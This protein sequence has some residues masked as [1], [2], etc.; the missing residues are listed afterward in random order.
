[1]NPVS[2]LP[3]VA[4]VHAEA[5]REP[6]DP[7]LHAQVE[8][9]WASLLDQADSIADQITLTL[10][11]RDQGLFQRSARPPGRGPGQHPRADPAGYR[12]AGRCGEP[13]SKA[14]E[15]WR[16]TGRRRARQGVPM[17]LILSA[18]TLGTRALWEALLAQAASGKLDVEDQ[19]LLIAGQRVWSALDVQ[20]AVLIES[21]RRESARLQ[22]RDL[23]RQQ[24]IL[25]ALIE[26]RGADPHFATEA[27]EVLGIGTGVRI[28]C[29]V[30]P[31]DGSLDEPLTAPEDRLERLEIA[32]HWHV[33]GGLY[34]GLLAGPLPDDDG[35]VQLL[36]PLAVGRVGLASSAD[37]LA[38]F[39]TAF[40]L[41]TRA[42]ET[43]PRGTPCVVSVTER[44]PE[45]L[46][47]GNPQVGTAAAAAHAGTSPGAARPSRPDT[48]RHA[49]G[50]DP[51]RRLAD[52]RGA[53]AVLPPQHRHLPDEAD[54]AAHRAQPDRP[55]RQA[56]AVARPADARPLI[57]ADPRVRRRG[58]RPRSRSCGTAGGHAGCRPRAS[59]V[60]HRG[61]R[62][63]GPGSGVG[64]RRR[65]SRRR[66]S[67][68]S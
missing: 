38:G 9:A 62:A 39:A 48:G 18:H 61:S 34:F 30:A 16:E 28:A 50:A 53:G 63:G 7:V 20:N 51:P 64:A 47:A 43:L 52:P 23:Q 36:T 57:V 45:V 56:A 12:G 19:V 32:S 6:D 1:M 10:L 66:R 22:R 26:G 25:D 31:Y 2:D 13:G 65:R 42:A 35:L 4:R 8:R 46:L 59:G 68:P 41:A 3:T 15:L 5:A 44:L 27:Y 14:V 11:E 29:V 24:S 33:R 55:A 40:Q 49:G 17:E 58:G 37:G 21:Y 60:P 54:R 67:T